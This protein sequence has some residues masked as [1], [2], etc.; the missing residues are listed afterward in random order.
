[1]NTNVRGMNGE[2]PHNSEQLTSLP[3]GTLQKNAVLF[4]MLGTNPEVSLNS[5]RDSIMTRA[6]SKSPRANIKRSSAIYAIINQAITQQATLD[7]ALVSTKGRVKI[8]SCHMRIDPTKTHKEATYQ[9]ILDILKLSP[10]YNAFLISADVHEIYM[11]HISLRVPNKEFV[12]SPLHDALVTFLKSLGYKGAL[13]YVADMYIDHMYQPWR[14]FGSI[15]NKCLSGKTIGL[16]RLRQSRVQI[17]QTSV[18]RRESMPYPRFTKVII[19]HFLSK[20]KSISKRQGLFM[21]SIKD[22]DILGRLKF[23]RKVVVLKK[24]RKGMKTPATSKKNVTEKPTSDEYD[25]EHEERLIRRKPTG[26]VIRDTPNV[27]TKKTLDQSKKLK[28]MEMLSEA[29]QLKANILKAIKVS[30]R[31]YRIHQQSRG[32]SKGAGITPEVPDE[33]K[34][35]TKGLSKGASITHQRFLMSQK[36]RLQL[37]MMNGADKETANDEEIHMNEEVHS[38]EEELHADVLIALDDENVHVDDKKH[39][40]TV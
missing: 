1:M 3:R 17:L 21:N 28:G 12:A 22:D 40:V 14:T 33:P 20:H 38:D 13:E 27:S 9:V 34:G 2:K 7:E 37:K 31:T 36:A 26:V 8:V 25:D 6:E 29:A 4:G 39:D 35:K 11:H 32:S 24:A 19:N 5:S 16:D 30:K 15:I 23:V 18:R 10:C